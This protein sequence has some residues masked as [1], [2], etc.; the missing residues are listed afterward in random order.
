MPT[1]VVVVVVLRY[2]LV[3]AYQNVNRCRRVAQSL[4]I[5]RRRHWLATTTMMMMIMTRM[6]TMIT[7]LARQHRVSSRSLRK[8]NNNNN[9]NNKLNNHHLLHNNNLLALC[10]QY[11][12]IISQR[13][14]CLLEYRSLTI[15]LS[16][17]DCPMNSSELR[18]LLVERRKRV[19]RIRAGT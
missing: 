8:N 5:N 12:P 6:P 14:L 19:T 10:R 11:C 4:A 18:A 1:C 3:V 2:R 13:N 17:T 9:N 16:S 7:M 15:A